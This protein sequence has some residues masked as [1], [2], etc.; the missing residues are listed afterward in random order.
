M[1]IFR[2]LTINTVHVSVCSF[3][4]RSNGK[5]F[6]WSMSIQSRTGHVNMHNI[7]DV[8]YIVFLE[9]HAERHIWIE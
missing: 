8:I 6:G 5:S 9:R 7:F 1:L 3:Q 2:I 4:K